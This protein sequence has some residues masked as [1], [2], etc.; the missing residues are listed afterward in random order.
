MSPGTL[1]VLNLL[2]PE[3]GRMVEGAAPGTEVITLGPRSTADPALHQAPILLGGWAPSPVFDVLDELGVRW[4]HLAATGL[5]RFPAE[6]FRGRLVTHA[7]GVF[8]V[9]M[10]EYVVA[11]ILDYVKLIPERSGLSRYS[12]HDPYRSLAGQTVGLFGF[13]SVGQAVATR[14]AVF[15]VRL[16]AFKRHPIAGHSAVHLVSSVH[17]LVRGV[18][19][20]VLAAPRTPD[21]ERVINARVISRMPAGSHLVNVAR[22]ALVDHGALRAAL[23]TGHLGRA[24]LD[25]TDPEPLPAGHWLLEHPQARVTPHISWRGADGIR[26]VVDNFVDNLRRYRAGASL[27]HQVKAE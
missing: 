11:A 20:L 15:E 2:G 13:G 1:R 5:D 10:A 23:D 22:G 3:V 27:L 16:K 24:T 14:L 7:R 19:H 18:D 21:T 12:A 9:P 26:A 25:A 6:L 8:A 4:V 17:E